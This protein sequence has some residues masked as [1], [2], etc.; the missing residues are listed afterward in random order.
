MKLPPDVF[1]SNTY[2]PVT[3]DGGHTIQV[4]NKD[5]VAVGYR[6]RFAIIDEYGFGIVVLTAGDSGAAAAKV[7]A[8]AASMLVPAA[9]AA[10]REA[11]T[12][13]GYI[14][15]FTG[16]GPV[17]VPADN[18]TANVPI[19][20]TIVLD[21]QSLRISTLSRNGSDILNGMG[22]IWNAS[23]GQITPFLEAKPNW[24]LYPAEIE[25][26][27][28]LPDGRKVILEEWRLQWDDIPTPATDLPGANIL[29]HYC[30]K[31]SYEDW[32]YYGGESLD[33]FIFVKEAKT[34]NVL[35]F[36]APFLRSG[37]LN[38]A[39]ASKSKR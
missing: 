21:G 2:D 7:Y 10:A 9:E 22:E 23:M 12:Q 38:R 15:I 24:R 18:G 3:G 14:G 4:A 36:E 34:G 28:T 29:A 11:V 31:W 20:A 6:S 27:S 32:I 33:R 25:T 1:F 16:Q 8:A 17:T 35:G 39:G 37:V 26:P 19:N 30:P 13:Q 5:G